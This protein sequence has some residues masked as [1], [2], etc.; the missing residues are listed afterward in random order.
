MQAKRFICWINRWGFR[1]KEIKILLY[2]DL[3]EFKN[4][5]LSFILIWFLLPMMLYLLLI[6]P[7]AD[8]FDGRTINIGESKINYESW[9]LP[10]IWICASSL[11]SFLYS[12]SRLRSLMLSQGQL[13]KYLK[14]PLS[15][16][17]LL[18]SILISS[19]FFSI[20][21]LFIS[22]LI[23]LNLDIQGV[24]ID[25]TGLVI[26]FC[27]IFFLIMFFSILGLLMSFYVKDNLISGLMIFTMF[28]FISF[29][30]GT[31]LPIPLESG[32]NFFALIKKLPAYEIVLNT[33]RVMGLELINVTALIINALINSILFA[34]V[35][36]ISYKKFR[37]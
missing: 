2:R 15:N 27:N 23:T 12:F 31:I 37:K 14:A 8:F 20:M 21:Q 28:V 16:G 25:S 32:N 30:L 17:Q 13:Q 26:I 1:V 3:L 6:S 5:Y 36:V 29:T 24:V 19:I 11:F 10:G 33:H 34:L 22:I 4:K 18:L 9:S 7:I 35:V